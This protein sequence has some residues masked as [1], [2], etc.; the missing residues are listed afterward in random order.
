MALVVAKSPM[1]CAI[2]LV[3]NHVVIDAKISSGITVP[4]LLLFSF[5]WLP[6]LLREVSLDYINKLE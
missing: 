4:F 1:G 3:E 5:L 6:K 2:I